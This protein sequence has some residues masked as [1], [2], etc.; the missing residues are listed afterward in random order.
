MSKPSRRPRREDIKERGRK[1]N[2]NTKR[3]ASASS[4]KDA[5]LGERR[6]CPTHARPM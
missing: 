3:F 6:R 4:P 5:A 2:S 1:K